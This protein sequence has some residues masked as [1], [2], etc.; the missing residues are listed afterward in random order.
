M[1]V[2][3][4]IFVPSIMRCM[5]K[6]TFFV[7]LVLLVSCSKKPKELIGTWEVNSPYY[8]ATYAIEEQEGKIVG[9]VIYYNDDT[10]IYTETGSEKDIFLHQLQKKDN[11]YIDAFSGATMTKKNM[12]MRLIGKDTLEV[13][14]YIKGTP[15]REFWIKKNEPKKLNKNKSDSPNHNSYNEIR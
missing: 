1:N 13:T 6:R 8:S 2:E 11:L 12:T 3:G 10:Y 9:R 5:M 4:Y 14:S 15:L 7:I